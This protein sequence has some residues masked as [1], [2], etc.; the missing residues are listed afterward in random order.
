[1]TATAPDSL[2]GFVFGYF[3][4]DQPVNTSGNPYGISNF[5]LARGAANNS[6]SDRTL[7]ATDSITPLTIHGIAGSIISCQ[8]CL[9]FSPQQSGCYKFNAGST[10]NPRSFSWTITGRRTGTNSSGDTVILD[11]CLGKLEIGIDGETSCWYVYDGT[12]KVVSTIPATTNTHSVVVTSSF[13]SG[14]VTIA[15]TGG[16]ETPQTLAGLTPVALA[17]DFTDKTLHL[18]TNNGGSKRANGYGLY[19]M[20]FHTVETAANLAAVLNWATA[21]YGILT[22]VD[23]TLIVS[24]HSWAAAGVAIGAH[25]I[26]LGISLALPRVRVIPVGVSGDKAV[27]YS[28]TGTGAN[29]QRLALYSQLRTGI[30]TGKKWAEVCLMGTNEI[31][32]RADTQTASGFGSLI[33]SASAATRAAAGGKYILAGVLP[34]YNFFASGSWTYGAGHWATREAVRQTFLTKGRDLL[35]AGTIDGFVDPIT[36]YKWNFYNSEDGLIELM[37]T[38]PYRCYR[39]DA[40]P[41][42]YFDPLDL[43]ASGGTFYDGVHIVIGSVEYGMELG[44]YAAGVMR[45]NRAGGGGSPRARGRMAFETAR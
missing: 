16:Y 13:G 12:T 45:W 26:P 22:Q 9:G 17:G 10:V 6:T 18:F 37:K 2:P 36:N 35:T 40:A 32:D 23:G 4:E 43:A 8:A 21:T 41:G 44:S 1:M 34:V 19:A 27:A 25:T 3:A 29:N 24:G 42:G 28:P 30:A 33:S 39:R 7:P 20:T 31:A 14:G 5:L 38:L 15:G 11:L